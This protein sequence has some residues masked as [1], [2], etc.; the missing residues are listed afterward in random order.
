MQF[1]STHP[2]ALQGALLRCMRE[3]SADIDRLVELHTIN[4]VLTA[5][6]PNS[7]TAFATKWAKYI[8]GKVPASRIDLF[9]KVNHWWTAS[10]DIAASLKA[11]KALAFFELML[12][13]TAPMLYKNDHWIQYITGQPALWIPAHH[14]RLLH[15]NTLLLLLRSYVGSLCLSE[16]FSLHWNNEIYDH[17]D[18]IQL[19]D[20]FYCDEVA[21]LQLVEVDDAFTMVAG[22][23]SVQY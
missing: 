2:I 15:P 17:L 21:I 9:A 20:E 23:L 12:L 13:C 7:D 14:C 22:P 1:A 19:S 16:W 3:N 4:R 5:S 8:G 11:T 18:E 10:P 6:E